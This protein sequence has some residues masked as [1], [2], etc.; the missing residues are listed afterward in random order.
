[1]LTVFVSI[2]KLKRTGTAYMIELIYN[3]YIQLP[4]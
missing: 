3:S 2:F 4:E 1:M